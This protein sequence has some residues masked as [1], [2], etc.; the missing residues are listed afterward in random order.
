M[1]ISKSDIKELIDTTKLT[2]QMMVEDDEI[3]DLQAE[4]ARKVYVAYSKHFGNDEAFQL[5]L[6]SIKATK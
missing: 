6:A 5:T 4:V 1:E 2:L 3:Y